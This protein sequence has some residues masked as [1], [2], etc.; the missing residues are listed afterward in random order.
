MKRKV[1]KLGG[2]AGDIPCSTTLRSAGGVSFQSVGPTTAKT[3]FWDR[4][5]RDQGSRR[6][7]RSAERSGR[8]ERA[9]SGLDKSAHRYFGVGTLGWHLLVCFTIIHWLI[10]S[11]NTTVLLHFVTVIVRTWIETQRKAFLI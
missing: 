1:L 5:V 9:D 6:S 7:Q 11:Q 3:R 4:E 8:E 10:H 2:D